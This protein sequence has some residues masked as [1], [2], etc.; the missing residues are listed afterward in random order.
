M[1][2][3]NVIFGTITLT[4][5]LHCAAPNETDGTGAKN[6]TR[7]MTQP[8]IANGA[9]DFIP[10]FPGSDIRGR[11]RRKAA[12]HVMDALLSHGEKTPRGLYN[13]LCSGSMD[14]APEQ[15]LSVEEALRARKH[16]YMGL[17]GGGKRIL[18]SRFSPSD[19]VPILQSTID[20]KLVP[21]HYADQS[22]VKFVPTK[23]AENGP[24]PLRGF[25]LIHRRQQVKIDDTF[26]V[27]RPEEIERYVDDA[28]NAVAAYQESITRNKSDRKSAKESNAE[29]VAKLDTANI[30]TLD[31]VAAGTV[32][33]VRVDMMDI[34]TDA[35]RGL[36]FLSL[37]DLVNEQALGGF[38]RAG[39]GRF[40][41]QL[42]SVINGEHFPLFAEQADGSYA[43]SAEA[44]KYALA[45]TDELKLL[46][47]AELMEFYESRG[48]K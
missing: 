48:G 8:I 44:A 35:Q 9:R 6:H 7:T 27:L 32:M 31:A 10:Y 13:G 34:L 23:M 15:D 21:S 19:L 45:A 14:N 41:P 12:A 11:L 22:E 4:T 24:V 47:V 28:A 25:E 33:Y 37:R 30:F 18:R 42:T 38:V 26:R 39:F 16:I 17:F 29:K 46:S 43:L 40:A 3:R 2:A 1:T 36:L 5:P 20:A